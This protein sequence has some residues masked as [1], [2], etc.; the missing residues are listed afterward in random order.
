[1]KKLKEKILQL[2]LE[3]EKLK[4]EVEN[5]WETNQRNIDTLATEHNR[6]LEEIERLQK[7][8]EAK[9][10]DIKAKD[11][12]YDRMK[13]MYEQL[14]DNSVLHNNLGKII[15]DVVNNLKN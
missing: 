7:D 14:R 10:K 2:E 15:A 12:V 5:A 9:E 4:K 13:N 11:F 8:I 3:N 6:M 1:M